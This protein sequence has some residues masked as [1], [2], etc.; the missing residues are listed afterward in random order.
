MHLR[1]NLMTSRSF[2]YSAK[3][4]KTDIHISH[5]LNYYCHRFGQIFF[6]V[7]VLSS[8]PKD[9]GLSPLLIVRK[10]GSFQAA[11]SA[12][13]SPSSTCMKNQQNWTA[14]CASCR[15]KKLPYFSIWNCTMF[16]ERPGPLQHLAYS[17]FL[18]WWKNNV[19]LDHRH[20]P[21]FVS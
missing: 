6:F 12:I 15:K 19:S 18:C 21:F 5:I 8:P 9:M 17:S 16:I 1:L 7:W 11:I 10:W 20:F 2:F 4:S 13:T 3:T 14:L